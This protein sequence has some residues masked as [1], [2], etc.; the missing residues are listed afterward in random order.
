MGILESLA[1]IFNIAQKTDQLE[2]QERILK[3]K[4]EALELEEQN[5]VLKREN[6]ELKIAL[7]IKKS[8]IFHNDAYWI[9][10]KEN[11]FEGPYCPKCYEDK[12]KLIHLLCQDNLGDV[13][14]PGKQYNFNCP[15]CGSHVKSNPFYDDRIMKIIV[16]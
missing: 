12:G 4:K 13:I 3:A 6:N 10:K 5:Q 2:L 15:N 16:R 8:V 14:N 11:K 9:A 1:E 7:E